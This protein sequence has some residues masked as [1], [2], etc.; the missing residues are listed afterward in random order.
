[1][2]KAEIGKILVIHDLGTEMAASIFEDCGDDVM[3]FQAHGGIKACVGCF[4]CWVKTPGKCVIKDDAYKLPGMLARCKRVILVS[5]NCYGGPSPLVK[6][7]L[8]RSIGYM[9][10]FFRLINDEMHHTMRYEQCISLKACYY[11]ENISSQEKILA[12]DILK[13]NAINFGAV[14]E[15]VEFYA[16]PVGMRGVTV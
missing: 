13:A 7:A 9:M 5:E 12:Q 10:P 16:S 15:G 8:D 11:G 3:L 4:G 1:M 2:D 6:R 14:C